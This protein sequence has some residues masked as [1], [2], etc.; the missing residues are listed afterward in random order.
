MS[1]HPFPVF[2]LC[3]LLCLA[4][5]SVQAQQI[6]PLSYDMPNGYGQA[7]GGGRNYWDASYNGSGDPLLDYSPLSGGTGD[8]TD[9]VI[10]TQRWDEVENDAG[11]GP[12]VGWNK[13]DP[14]VITF[15]FDGV[16]NFGSVTAWHDDANGWGD[17]APPGSITVT[18]GGM[19]QRFDIVDPAS[20]TPFGSVLAL[21][22]GWTGDTLVLSLERFNNGLMLSEVTFLAAAVPEPATWALWAAGAGLLVQRRMRQ[23]ASRRGVAA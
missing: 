14:W 16:Q 4:A 13:G 5:G 22:P 8:L 6:Q 1:I 9:G 7:N 20:D 23:A 3:A 12:Y 21:G 19:S 15:H 10:A 11:T 2:P 18:V 17:I